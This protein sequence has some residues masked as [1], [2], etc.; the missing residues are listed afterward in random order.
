MNGTAYAEEEVRTVSSFAGFRTWINS[1]EHKQEGADSIRSSSTALVGWA[2]ETKFTNYIFA[3]A[4]YLLSAIDY[5]FGKP[6]GDLEVER[7]DLDLA[8]GYQSDNVGLFT[9]YR[10]SQFMQQEGDAW[11][12]TTIHGPLVGIRGTAPLNNTL[13]LFGKAT[14]LPW[15]TKTTHGA[16]YGK[17]S[18]RGWFA[19]AGASYIFDKY[20]AGSLGYKYESTTGENTKV[21]DIFSGVTVDVMYSF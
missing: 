6:T 1:S 18:A 4:S 14:Y 11:S 9:G 2:A 17:E 19:E 7:N 8:I 3:G 13:S 10:S 16:T 5:K 20:F 15:S 12:K 21:T